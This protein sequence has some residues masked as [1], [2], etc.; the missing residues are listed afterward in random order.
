MDQE[1]YDKGRDALKAE[2]YKAAEKN[3]REAFN[4]IEEHHEL[5]NK[6][7]SYLGLSQVLLSDRNGLLLCRDAASSE[8]NDGDV[9]LY[10]ACAEWHTENRERAIDAVSRGCKIDGDHELLQRA[11]LLLDSRRG[12]V[13]PFLPRRHMLNR[14]LGF[15]VRRTPTRLSVH[16]LL[17]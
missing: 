4:S 2:D 1:S 17:Y 7:A 9:F 12:S 14:V 8:T 10:L 13:V 5:Y 15:L 11:G 6:L 16:H 3:F